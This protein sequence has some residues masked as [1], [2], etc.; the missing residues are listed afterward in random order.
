[1]SDLSI[2]QS[3]SISKDYNSLVCLLDALKCVEILR[4]TQCSA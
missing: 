1:M 4:D 2:I 3:V